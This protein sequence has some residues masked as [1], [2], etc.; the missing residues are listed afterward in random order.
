M[1]S[2]SLALKKLLPILVFIAGSGTIVPAQNTKP[3]KKA[4]KKAAIRNLVES[5]RYDFKPMTVTPM[6][7]RTRQLTS[8]YDLTITKETIASYLPYFG[9]AYSAPMDPTSGGFQF[10][11]KDF[12]YTVSTGK[13]GGW[14]ITIKPK[15][16]RD[17]QQMALSISDDGY[18]SLQIV[19]TQRQSISFYGTITAIRPPRK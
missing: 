9:Q 11:S 10:T 2:L 1:K 6:G 5:Q 19:S 8:D 3:T 17:V 7:G 14:D 16:Y 4:E 13:K 18:T 12:E 15:D